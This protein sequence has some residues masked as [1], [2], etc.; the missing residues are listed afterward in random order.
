VYLISFKLGHVWF[1]SATARLIQLSRPRGVEIRWRPCIVRAGDR[2]KVRRYKGEV[3]I[4]L[5]LVLNVTPLAIIYVVIY[6]YSK[7]LKVRCL[8]GWPKLSGYI[9]GT[10]SSNSVYIFRGRA[11]FFRDKAVVQSFKIS[12]LFTVYISLLVS[13]T[14]STVN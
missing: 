14:S 12:A 1:S 10:Y 13:G 9:W 7:W 11:V 3:L 4:A 2:C 6:V 8:I 5:V